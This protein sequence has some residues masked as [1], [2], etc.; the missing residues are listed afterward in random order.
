MTDLTI[1]QLREALDTAHKVFGAEC[2]AMQKRE[3]KLRE[4]LEDIKKHSVL[5]FE[6][7]KWMSYIYIAANEALSNEYKDDK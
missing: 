1:E 7:I 4:A 5:P 2:D 6:G 3:A